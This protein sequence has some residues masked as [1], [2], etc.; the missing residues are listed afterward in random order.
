MDPIRGPLPISLR[1][2]PQGLI[3][4]LTPGRAFTARVETIEGRLLTLFVGNEKLEAMLAEHLPQNLFKPGQVIRLKVASLGPP[5]VLTIETKG[6]KD[7]KPLLKHTSQTLLKLL[8][9][10]EQNFK[11]LDIFKWQSASPKKAKEALFFLVDHFF[12]T[13]SKDSS[14]KQTKGD[15]K[16]FRLEIREHFLKLWQEGQFVI[17]FLFGDRVSWS[18]LYEDREIAFAKPGV[19]S[20]LL[21]LF[22]SRL[23]YLEARFNLSPKLLLLEISFARDEA[24]AKARKALSSLYEMFSSC[25]DKVIIKLNTLD[26]YPGQMLRLRG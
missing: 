22:L 15:A 13:L 5:L 25:E 20:F 24:L 16:K 23:G 2:I 14:A 18:Y 7:I 11:L 3:E 12:K 4:I 26:A 21:V 1:N 17:P 19:R 9:Q 6:E 10:E 8:P